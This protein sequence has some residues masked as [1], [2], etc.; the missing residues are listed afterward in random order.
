MR[1]LC[2]RVHGRLWGS[3]RKHSER[4]LE[5]LGRASILLCVL[6]LWHRSILLWLL[7]RIMLLI[8][9]MLRLIWLIRLVRL[10]VRRYPPLK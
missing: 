7:F 6:L 5:V 4:L 3:A 1:L 2:W 10:V 8:V 9:L